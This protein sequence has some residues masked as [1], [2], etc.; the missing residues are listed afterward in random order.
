M[1]RRATRS[2][3]APSADISTVL[4]EK[5]QETMRRLFRPC[6]PQE[7]TYA[8]FAEIMISILAGEGPKTITSTVFLRSK[9]QGDWSND[10][11]V[12]STSPWEPEDLFKR[13]L[14]ATIQFL[15]NENE[16]IVLAI[17][18]T[19]HWRWSKKVPGTAWHHDALGPKFFGKGSGMPPLKWGHQMLHAVLMIPPV[20]GNAPTAIP[21]AYEPILGIPKKKK[22]KTQASGEPVKRGRPKGFKPSETLVPDSS[23][24][25]IK[26]PPKATEQALA[27][28]KRVRSW[29]D[30]FGL[31]ERD[32]MVVVDASYCNGTVLRNLPKRTEIIGRTRED[33]CLYAPIAQ[34]QGKQIYGDRIPTPKQI[35]QDTNIPHETRVFKF[36]GDQYQF[37]WKEANPVLWKN[38]SKSRPL[39]LLVTLPVPHGRRSNRG[40]RKYG[41]LLTTKLDGDSGPLLQA[42]LWR[43]EIENLHRIFKTTLGMGQTQCLSSSPKIFA[44][45]AATWAVFSL[46]SRSVGG[47]V[48]G[49]QQPVLSK[50]QANKRRWREETRLRQ[51]RP[52]PKY[53][54]TAMD[55]ITMLRS[56]LGFHWKNGVL[57][58][59]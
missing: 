19:C 39:R 11:K 6:F 35:S 8:R 28:I 20:L 5:F 32:L 4:A 29:L 31:Q 12:F 21:V 47:E 16:P 54:P 48:R 42:Y 10:Y 3:Q 2:H 50:W 52:M 18:D 1:P 23:I 27:V 30:D 45:I 15:P 34:K 40:Y 36:G 9:D 58:K 59:A 57:R 37:R 56:G 22:K 38:G 44:S 33:A 46:V 7:R 49:D 25:Q 43:I 41:Y 24:A 13:V 17:D 51:G 53:R 26:T 14:G 55:N